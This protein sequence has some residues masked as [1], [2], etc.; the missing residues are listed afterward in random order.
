MA[1]AHLRIIPH[2]STLNQSNRKLWRTF[3]DLLAATDRG[4]FW[5]RNPPDSITWVVLLRLD[6]IEYY[7]SLPETFADVFITKLKGFE[8]WRRCTVQQAPCTPPEGEGFALCLERH[9]M[10]ALT[11]DY[12]KQT[13]PVREVLQVTQE[14][15]ADDAAALIFSFEPVTRRRWQAL[16][17][18]AWETWERGDMPA[19]AEFDLSR[20][21]RTGWLL[22]S[23]FADEVRSLLVDAVRAVEGTFFAGQ[24]VGAHAPARALIS[25]PERA[26]LLVNGNLSSATQHK[27]NLPVY[28]STLGMV[29]AAETPERR[30][31]LAHSLHSAFGEL[32]GDNRLA[33]CHKPTPCVLSCDEIGKLTQLPT[34]DVQEE[35]KGALEANRQIEIEIPAC[36]A[37]PAGIHMGAAEHR[38][39]EYPIHLPT[40]DLD[41]LMT[42]R[43]MIGSPRMGKDQAAINLVVESRMK[44]GIGAVIIDVIDERNGHRGMADAIRD[45]LPP[46]HVIDLNLGD[47]EYPV[48][49]GLQGIT[50]TDNERIASSRLAQELTNFFVEDQTQHQTREYL[51]ECAKAVGGDLLGVRLMLTNDAYRQ[52]RIAAL[53]AAGRDTALLRDFHSMTEGRRG[54]IAGP[55]MVRLGEIMGDEALRPI[56]CQQA[57]K[58]DPALWMR[59]GKVVI[60]RIPSRDLGEAAVR[61]LCHWIVLTTFLTKLAQGG[62]GAPTWLILNEPHQFLSPG[63][64]HFCQRLLAEG[65]KYRIAPVFLFHNFKQLPGDFVEVLMSSS[66][67]WH[68]FKN[69]NANVYER[70]RPYLEPTYTPD[71]AMSTTKRFHYI[72]CWLNEAGEYQAP[73]MLAAPPMVKDRYPTRDHTF[74]TRRHS[75]QYGRPFA[76]VEAEIQSRQSGRAAV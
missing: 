24:G 1:D 65:P 63:L 18:Y 38:G 35:F 5:R 66:L 3:H 4:P 69:T 31:M 59:E 74:L 6:A 12:S 14:M 58:A 62:Q 26:A 67:N 11:T 53:E 48:G 47:F 40:A 68:I 54:Q 20:L 13:T 2:H 52:G 17:E 21:L 41:M 76:E 61:T 71:L 51:R 30:R 45:H 49:I 39:T 29:V 27:R 73:F 28:K 55:I 15:R 75:R 57:P 10:F 44:H 64:V 7:V 50:A 9:D 37:D 60:Y 34:A 70:L 56:F 36:F 22:V 43:A 8:P 19:R 46:E 32:A 25:D 33:L 72:A 23:R 16:G 42:S